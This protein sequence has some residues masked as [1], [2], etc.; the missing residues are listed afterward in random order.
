[1][2]FYSQSELEQLGFKFLGNNVLLSKKAS[3]YGHERI[4]IGD[5]SRID[6][7]SVISAGLGGVHIG[8]NVH[9][10]IFSSLI[11]AGK[12]TLS[13]F[14]NISSRVSI[15]SSNDDYSGKSM[16][17]PTIPESYKKVNHADV[18]I[19]KHTIVGCGTVILPGVFIDEGVAIGALSLVN[20]DCTNWGIYS[21][22][23]IKKIKERERDLLDLERKYI[24]EDSNA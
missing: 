4:S 16:S 13:D 5:N 17:N 24:N 20:I 19:G 11:G 7:F 15:Y 14:S 9:I 3:L 10:A 22:T 6:D 1:M 21:G 23:P 2:A 12:I 18:Y 8:R